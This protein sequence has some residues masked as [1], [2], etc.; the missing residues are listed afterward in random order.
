MDG[1]DKSIPLPPASLQSFLKKDLNIPGL[2]ITNHKTNFTNPFYNS[3]WDTLYAINSE[4]L[5]QHLAD[6]AR[7]VAATTYQLATGKT[8]DEGITANMTLVITFSITIFLL[9]CKRSIPWVD[10]IKSEFFTSFRLLDTST[11]VF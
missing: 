4:N 10:L 6:V 7:T 9:P 5:V 1:P 8:L 11:R 2:L 3:E